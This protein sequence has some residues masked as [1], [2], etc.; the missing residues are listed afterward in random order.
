LP[1]LNAAKNSF[2][3]SSIAS[4]LVSFPNRVLR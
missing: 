1:A 3:L 2:A 4:S